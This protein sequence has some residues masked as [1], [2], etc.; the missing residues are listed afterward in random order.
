MAALSLDQQLEA[1]RLYKDGLSMQQVAD[2]FS[3]H[4]GAVLYA[5]RKHYVARRTTTESNR[6]RF[7]SKPLSYNVK[8]DLT[9]EEERLKLAAT[10]LYWAEGYKVGS[11]IDFANSDPAM[12]VIFRRF[13]TEI[14]QIDESRLRASMYCYEG[15]DIESL[16]A[17]WSGVLKIPR[18]Q[19]QKP[20][21]KQAA[22][23]GPRGPRMIH[24]LVH[25]RYCDT[26]LLRQMLIWIDEYQLECVGGGVVNRDWL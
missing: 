11:S 4:L 12:V 19:F 20:Y 7:E 24:G 22:S 2:H 6:L 8:Q 9:R 17:F 1:I 26:K 21:I 15:Q 10:M 23:P 18:S 3:V 25:V 5:L 16:H 14:C 13:L